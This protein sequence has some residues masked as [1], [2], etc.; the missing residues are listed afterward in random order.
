MT[1]QQRAA[2]IAAHTA[3]QDYWKL[4]ELWAGNRLDEVRLITDIGAEIK[5]LREIVFELESVYPHVNPDLQD[6]E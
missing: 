2:I 3:L 4:L 6:L 5:S 1:H